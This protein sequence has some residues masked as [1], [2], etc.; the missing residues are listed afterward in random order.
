MQGSTYVP[1]NAD[2]GAS[3]QFLNGLAPTWTENSVVSSSASGQWDNPAYQM[4]IASNGTITV[5]E[6]VAVGT[7]MTTHVTYALAGTNQL[8][9]KDFTIMVMNSK[10]TS[11]SSSSGS[12]TSSSNPN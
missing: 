6:N 10:Q 4:K 1:T 2:I 11:G 5:G 3:G 7:S 9:R 8:I 12:S